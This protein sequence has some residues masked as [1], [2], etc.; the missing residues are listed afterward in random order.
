MNACICHVIGSAESCNGLNS[1]GEGIIYVYNNYGNFVTYMNLH[2]KCNSRHQ[3]KS[4]LISIKIMKL[5]WVESN[6]TIPLDRLWKS[7]GGWGRG[8]ERDISHISL[9]GI[10]KPITDSCDIPALP[11]IVYKLQ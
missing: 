5:L 7:Q 6:H 9:E 1:P 8:V 2:G 10:V 3:S 4:S 11:S